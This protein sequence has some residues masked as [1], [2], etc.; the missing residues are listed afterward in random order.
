MRKFL[1]L[2]T[3]LLFIGGCSEKFPF[4]GN[5]YQ[6]V[7]NNPLLTVSLSFSAEGNTFYGKVFNTYSGTYAAEGNKLSLQITS[8]TSGEGHYDI[9]A[10]E[11]DYFIQLQKVVSYKFGKNSLTLY[12]SDNYALTFEK[13]GTAVPQN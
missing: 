11:K 2:L 3:F 6:L 8:Q 13:I 1:T 7:Q 10:V 4:Q 5:E 12:T 9:M